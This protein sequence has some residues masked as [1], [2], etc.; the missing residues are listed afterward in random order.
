MDRMPRS[1]V[2]QI[3]DI[4]E[5]TAQQL[6]PGIEV[7][8]QGSYR[9]GKETCGDVDIHLTHP[10]HPVRIPDTMLGEIV[11]KLNALWAKGCIAFHLTV[12]NGMTKGLK[13]ED[14]ER[15]AISV[16][17][18]AWRNT[19]PAK[20]YFVEE[21]H[22]SFWMG[23]FFSPVKKNTRRRVDIKLY[24][25][26]ERAFATVY[27]TGNGFLN[28]SMRLWSKRVF[29]WRLSDHGLFDIA[30]GKRVREA[31]TEREIFDHLKLVYKEPDERDSFD[32]L[33]SKEG[34]LDENM[35]LSEKEFLEEDNKH[36]WVE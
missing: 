36:V 3:K 9:R 18:A 6:Y 28:R 16:P 25:Y 10:S 29:N 8:V 13:I 11:G 22:K 5:R 15:N 19:K 7:T 32:A 31:T 24:P 26:R 27:F 20:R 34:V 4:V 2:E 23:C 1:E 17:S 12:L 14:Y 30:T 35:Q 21:D 33:E